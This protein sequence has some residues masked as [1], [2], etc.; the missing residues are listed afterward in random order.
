MAVLK[1]RKIPTQAGDEFSEIITKKGV[2]RKDLFSAPSMFNP[3]FRQIEEN[4]NY[5]IR[6]EDTLSAIRRN[7]TCLSRLLGIWRLGRCS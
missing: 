2:G 1:G 5:A 3:V 7:G 6:L 4:K